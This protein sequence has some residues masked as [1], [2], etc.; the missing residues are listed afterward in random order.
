MTRLT[1]LNRLHGF[2]AWFIL[3]ALLLSAGCVP[4]SEAPAPPEP[5]AEKKIGVLSGDR[6]L[7]ADHGVYWLNLEGYEPE[8]PLPEQDFVFGWQKGGL[9]AR[10]WVLPLEG[11]LAEEAIALAKR[12]GWEL[13]FP[14]RIAWQG[15]PAWDAVVNDDV[16]AGRLR[17]LKTDD[18]ILAVAALAPAEKAASKA[19]ELA[20]MIEGLRL[21]PPGDLLHTVRHPA[22][23]LSAVAMWY[24]GT[25]RNWPL[26]QEYNRLA[27]PR[28]SLGQDILIPAKLVWRWDPLPGWV[29]RSVQHRKANDDEESPSQGK[30]LELELL[31]A[32]PK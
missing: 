24:T 11:G 2:W 27:D 30:A 1:L 25:V 4:V 32:G 20:A 22:E 7:D 23:T 17:L 5:I 9:T 26:L 18:N 28:L 14:R 21:L 8:W 15:R 3:A 16:L 10:L 6:W 12:Q 13:S 29:V 31:P 19:P